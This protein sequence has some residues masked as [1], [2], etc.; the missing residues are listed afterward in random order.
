VPECA[1]HPGVETSLRCVECE[2]PICP[3]DFLP[4]PVGYKCPECGRPPRSARRAVKPR[5]L[6]FA[7][8]AAG[9]VG[10]GGPLAAATLGF[11]FW[12]VSLLLGVL[13]AEAARRAS[14]G[15]RDGSVAAVAGTAVVIGTFVAGYGVLGMVLAAGAAVFSVMSNR[16]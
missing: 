8:L 16:W 7:A 3:K 14:G 11:R 15:H 12:L 10:L 4:T 5:Q 13:T 9:A 6:A 1:F 2:R